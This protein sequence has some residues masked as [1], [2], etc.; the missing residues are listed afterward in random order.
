MGCDKLPPKLIISG[1]TI[2]C[3]DIAMII[4][5][6][7]EKSVF[8]SELELTEIISLH[9]K[10]DIHNK[11]NYRPVSILPCISKLF[12]GVLIDQLH[13]HFKPLFSDH[14]GKDHCC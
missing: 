1:A 12:K 5:I 13:C 3:I 11:C 8:P 14:L 10:G 2:L 4:K 7:I 9:K 6:C